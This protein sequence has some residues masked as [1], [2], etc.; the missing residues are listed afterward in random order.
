[1]E[2][3]EA[4]IYHCLTRYATQGSNARWQRKVAILLSLLEENGQTA[5]DEQK[6]Y[7]FSNS[8]FDERCA[9][10]NLFWRVNVLL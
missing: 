9:G 6:M 5:C 7:V 8:E 3:L 10:L 4:R 1:M 2:A